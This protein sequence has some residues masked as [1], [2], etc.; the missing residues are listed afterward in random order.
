MSNVLSLFFL[1]CF[2]TT[3][4]AAFTSSQWKANQVRFPLTTKLGALST[5]DK[6]Y[7]VVQQTVSESDVCVAERVLVYICQS[8]YDQ[9]GALCM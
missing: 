7:Y 8:P 1:L 3:S 4:T 9:N 5:E 2:L 6:Q